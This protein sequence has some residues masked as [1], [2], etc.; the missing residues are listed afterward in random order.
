M[1]CI[2]R[3]DTQK[4]QSERSTPLQHEAERFLGF[5]CFFFLNCSSP[6]GSRKGYLFSMIVGQAS[7]HGSCLCKNKRAAAQSSLKRNEAGA[8]K[9]ELP[10]PWCRE[11]SCTCSRQLR[12][13]Q[14]GPND[15]S[16]HHHAALSV[17]QQS[18]AIYPRQ[19]TRI[20][21]TMHIFCLKGEIY[22]LH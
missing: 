10:E 1:S 3:I 6:S 9:Q 7:Q 11:D 14:S 19:D 17:L 18:S 4:L 5:F 21:E 22:A 12:F 15:S 8:E 13:L 20:M 16:H 2:I